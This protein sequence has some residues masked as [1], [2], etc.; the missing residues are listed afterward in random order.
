MPS[1]QTIKLLAIAAALAAAFAAGWSWRASI[2]DADLADFKLGLAKQAQDQRDMTI[3]VEAAQAAITEQSTE[4]LD[5]KAEQREKEIQ[6]VDR[7][8]IKYRDRWRDSACRL[9]D[10]WLSIYD[11]SLGTEPVPKAANP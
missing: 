2:A 4:R 1:L 9:P 6:Y 7:E 8:V 10:E 3:K 5:Q 11:A